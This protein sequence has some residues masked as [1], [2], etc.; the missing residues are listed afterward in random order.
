MWRPAL[1]IVTPRL[2]LVPPLFILGP[3]AVFAQ[4]DFQEDEQH[5][6]PE[7]KAAKG[8]THHFP[9]VSADHERG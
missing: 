6:R 1:S 3:L 8:Q 7:P 9:G 4:P 2:L 5:H